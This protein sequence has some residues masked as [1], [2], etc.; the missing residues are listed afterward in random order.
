MISFLRGKIL[1][2]AKDF[3]ILDIGNI[4]YKIF[5]YPKLNEKLRKGQQAEF[6]IHYHQREDNT[7]LFGFEKMEDL[8]FFEKLISVRGLGPKS[9]M[10]FFVYE[11]NELVSAILNK[12][13]VKF[14]SIP[15]VGKKTAE[16]VV[17]QLKNKFKNFE[18]GNDFSG[19]TETGNIKNQILDA[20]LSLGYSRQQATEAVSQLQEAGDVSLGLKECL[21][22]L[23]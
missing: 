7:S 20:L 22:Y 3:V 8:E 17:L 21:K 12:D 4:G 23:S 14:T 5:V 11:I 13:I 2:Q 6:F 15:G 10:G 19:Q 18:M 16:L 1:H 9:A